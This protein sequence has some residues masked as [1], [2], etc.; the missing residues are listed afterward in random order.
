[1]TGFAQVK[2]Q[3][4]DGTAFT[5]S[6]KSVNHRF[7]DPQLRLPP[8]M[9]ELEMKIRRILKE[10]LGRGHVE[11]ALSLERRGDQGFEFN[12]QLV[13]G[14]VSAFRKAAAEFATPGEPDL[15]VVF[16]MP[17]ALGE[18][19]PVDG[20]FEAAVLAGLE[21]AIEKLNSMREQEGRGFTQC[22]GHTEHHVQIRFAGCGKLRCG[23]AKRGDIA[24]NQLAVELKPLVP[25]PFQA[26][27]DL[28]M[29][30]P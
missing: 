7:L 16:R 28:N 15:N 3:A 1:M 4:G 9:D 13:S 24:G 8:D 26:Q 17:G 2:S 6:L 14:Y 19:T 23:F 10:R 21:H 20:T 22:A 29:P 11:I 5:L 25:P 27:G 18:A 30:A 12:R